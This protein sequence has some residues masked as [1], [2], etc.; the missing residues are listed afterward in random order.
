MTPLPP[1]SHLYAFTLLPSNL[2]TYTSSITEYLSSTPP[3]LPSP[4]PFPHTTFFINLV[5][6]WPFPSKNM[7]DFCSFTQV[8]EFWTQ[9]FELYIISKRDWAYQ[10]YTQLKA[11]R[12]A[13]TVSFSQTFISM[14]DH[15]NILG[16]HLFIQEAKTKSA[17][18]D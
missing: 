18:W 15:D 9:N 5:P 8:R 7:G 10:I 14:I 11:T 1:C 6:V 17:K 2:R 16:I 3:P 13:Q 4:S 12:A